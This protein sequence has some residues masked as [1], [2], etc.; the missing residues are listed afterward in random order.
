MSEQTAF[1][2]IKDCFM[3]T[4]LQVKDVD[5]EGGHVQFFV[6]AYGN[7]DSHNDIVLP[8]S[9]TKTLKEN[10]PNA[11]VNRL[12]HLRH[13]DSDFPLGNVIEATD[14]PDGL[15]LTSKVLPTTYGK[16][17]LILEQGGVYEHSIGYKTI[18]SQRNSKGQN[19]LIELALFEGSSVTWGSNPNTP[20]LGIKSMQPAEQANTL[21]DEMTKLYKALRL[22]GLSDDACQRLEIKVLQLKQ[23]ISDLLAQSL[24]T[25]EPATVSTQVVEEPIAVDLLGGFKSKLNLN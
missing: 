4:A 9:F 10:G 2:E 3:P 24:P 25:P 18:K 20:T 17:V 13:H 12:K 19:E 23:A 1:Y 8:G 14:H 21:L 7:V 6:A 15:I 22:G 11:A 5:T 16:D